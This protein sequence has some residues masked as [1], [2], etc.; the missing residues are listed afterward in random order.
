[1]TDVADL[2]RFTAIEMVLMKLVRD[3][4]ERT[5]DAKRAWETFPSATWKV[6]SDAAMR[7][8][9]DPTER[10]EFAEAVQEQLIFL[11]RAALAGMPEPPP[12]DPHRSD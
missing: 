10:A 6:F 1:M 3:S 11:T 2:A 12:E 5:P 8:T 4:A 7:V 9:D